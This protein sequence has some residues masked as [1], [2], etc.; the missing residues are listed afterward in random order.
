[1]INLY[2]PTYHKNLIS[3]LVS[4]TVK[5]Y[6]SDFSKVMESKDMISIPQEDVWVKLYWVILMVFTIDIDCI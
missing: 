1:M 2:K 6:A 4:I 3:Y 5:I